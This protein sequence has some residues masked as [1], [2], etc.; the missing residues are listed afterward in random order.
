[1]N[2]R[3]LLAFVLGLAAPAAMLQAS[4]EAAGPPAKVRLAFVHAGRA[5]KDAGDF[6]ALLEKAG[7]AVDLVSARDAARHSFKPYAAVLIGPD[8][9]TGW[10]DGG[11]P[12]TRPGFGGQGRF[13]RRGGRD[14]GR[15]GRGRPAEAPADPISRSGK[16]V[17]GLGEGGAA[18]FGRLGL[19]IGMRSVWHGRQTSV[20]PVGPEKSPVW[21]GLKAAHKEGKPFEVYRE[22]GHVGVH[23]AGKAAGLEPIGR[24]V[25]SETHF[26]LVQAQGR[27]VLW[28]FQAGPGKMT[29]GGK[30]LFIAVCRHTAGLG[31]AKAG[32]GPGAKE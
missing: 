14:G 19:P 7:F 27:Y 1:M 15:E 17:L 25:K 3:T 31:G 18:Y 26:P 12:G 24:E 20:L 10:G 11:R 5:G 32:K 23:V 2:R 6:K 16:P 28:G 8:T 29:A 21:S 4:G 9:R 22:T 30:E 13:D